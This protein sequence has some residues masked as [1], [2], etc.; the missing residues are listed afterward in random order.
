MTYIETKLQGKKAYIIPYNGLT[1]IKHFDPHK[2]ELASTETKT[3]GDKK[4]MNPRMAMMIETEI[5]KIM[6]GSNKP[7]PKVFDKKK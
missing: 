1:F 6:Q 2:V 7:T 5:K 3:E 4:E